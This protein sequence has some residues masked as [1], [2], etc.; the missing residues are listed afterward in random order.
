MSSSLVELE[1]FILGESRFCVDSNTG[2]WTPFD[3]FQ[4]V[5]NYYLSYISKIRVEKPLKE[6]PF[7]KFLVMTLRLLDVK[8]FV[9]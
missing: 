9:H 6:E 7:H 8:R 3:F 4:M 2:A 1:P 5:K